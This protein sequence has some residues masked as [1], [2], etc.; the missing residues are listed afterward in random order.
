MCGIAGLVLPHG[1]RV[2]PALLR[3]MTDAVAHRG[4][5]ADGYLV[6]GNVG[7]GHRRLAIIDTSEAANQPLTDEDGSVAV[8]LNGEIYNFQELRDELLERGYTFR[9][10]SDTEAIVHGW[11]EWGSDVVA[12]LRGMFAL[13]L[14]DARQ[15]RLLLARDPI[16][17]KPLYFHLSPRGLLFGSEIKA[18]LAAPW[19]G[20]ELD[21]KAVGEYLIYGSVA[22]EKSVYRELRRLPAGH[23]LR[24]DTRAASLEPAIEAYWRCPE[25]S[26]PGLAE[27]EWLDE[28]DRALAQSVRLRLISD[29]PLGA[30]LSGGV[31]S[32][33]VVAHMTRLA[34]GRVRTFCIGFRETGW[35][36]SRHAQA[37]ADHLGTDHHTEFVTPDAAAMLPELVEVYDE[38]FG[39]PSAIPTYYVAKLT[40]RHVTVALSG[41]G[42]DELFA[43]YKRYAESAALARLGGFLATPGRTAARQAAGGLRVGSFARRALERVAE[44]DF[45]L[46]HHALGW[47]PEFL[48]LL[49]PEVRAA[50][51]PP[52]EQEA[53][54]DFHRPEEADFL[55][56]CRYMDLHNYLP[57]QV[58]VKADRAAMRHALEVRCPLLDQEVVELALRMPAARQL[59]RSRQKL[60]LRKLA[61][62]YVPRALVDRPKQG[63]AVPL[64]RWLRGPLAP[65]LRAALGDRASLAWRFY[66]R[67]EAER[68]FAEHL[69]GRVNHEKS[70]WRLLVFHAWA[71]R[72]AAA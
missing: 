60:L 65:L 58:L 14:Y 2:D 1:E 27:E 71:A 22:G 68:R 31:D 69:G 13:V 21:S 12:R 6:Q 41:D 67:A 45:A 62:R 37:V 30:F 72:E 59:N 48:T 47:A 63:F 3:R 38:P 16:G 57:D 55:D 40:R 56:R 29:V 39:D 64:G 49:A 54:A 32:S 24:L 33:L 17:K 42:G 70:L 34:A 9:T 50:L 44:R 51:G 4:P 15:G 52:E 7:L 25:R 18:L 23:F 20:R 43:G 28:V 19:V 53:F 66:D 8:I 11:K 10:R 26:Q 61:E 5:D 46:Y 35:D 36:E